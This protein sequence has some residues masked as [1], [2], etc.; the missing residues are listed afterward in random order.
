MGFGLDDEKRAGRPKRE[1]GVLLACPDRNE[2]VP[3]VEIAVFVE[4][5]QIL[6]LAVL[7]TADQRD[8][9][10]TSGDARQRNPRRVDARSLLTHE[11]TRRSRNTVHDGDVAGQ[12]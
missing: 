10:L 3:E 1:T 2:F 7:R 12:Q 4:N 5:Q 8:V 11:G 9:A 6:A